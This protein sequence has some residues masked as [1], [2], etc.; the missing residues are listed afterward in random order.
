MKHLNGFFMYLTHEK[1]Y[2]PHTIEAYR[3]DLDQL[4][5]FCKSRHWELSDDL[6]DLQHRQARTWVMHLVDIGT[7]PRSVSRK[8]S[9]L[10]AHF[11]FLVRKGVIS[12]NPMTKIVVPKTGKKLPLFMEE[13]DVRMVLQQVASGE[14]FDT[15]RSWLVIR[16][17][18]VGGLRR[19]E[20]IGIR[21][22]DISIPDRQIRVTG[23]GAK[24]RLIP[25]DD[26]TVELIENYQKERDTLFV[27]T[28]YLIVTNKG[29]QAYPNM[30]YR[31][32]NDALSGNTSLARKS[33][34]VLRHTFATQL[35][36]NGA[37]LNA[38][39]E[40]LGHASLASTQVYTHTTI[41]RLKDIYKKAHPK[42]A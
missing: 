6:T 29:L 8:V 9:S 24:Q 27:G 40:L 23:K 18:Y 28:D 3:S 36:N 38:V 14:G 1:R 15:L 41:E 25:L 33:P 17:L 10:R 22:T 42:G 5:V 26:E 37:E 2:S 12:N 11:R 20:L 39:K 21:N 4:S 35:A 30:I 7:S 13:K 34:H 16:L 31:I 32:V 19:S